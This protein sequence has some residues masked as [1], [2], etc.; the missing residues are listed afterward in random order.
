MTEIALS[1][2]IVISSLAGEENRLTILS[3]PPRTCEAKDGTFYDKIMPECVMGAVLTGMLVIIG[4]VIHKV[5]W[6]LYD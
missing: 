5:N 6:T 4:W 1:A 3:F 2:M